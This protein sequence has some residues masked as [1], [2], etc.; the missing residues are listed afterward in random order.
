MRS[1]SVVSSM[2][3]LGVCL[4]APSDSGIIKATHA[5]L[6]NGGSTHLERAVSNVVDI[7]YNVI[8]GGVSTAVPRKSKNVLPPLRWLEGV[9]FKLRVGVAYRIALAMG[10]EVHGV[11]TSIRHICQDTAPCI[12][13]CNAHHE[14]ETP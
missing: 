7:V 14:I 4:S 2:P 12:P 6:T 8:F 10:Q 5:Q 1:I 11:A 3:K 9:N 13:L